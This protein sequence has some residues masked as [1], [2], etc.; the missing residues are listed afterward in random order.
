MMFA[1]NWSVASNRLYEQQPFPLWAVEHYIGHLAV[2]IDIDAEFSQ[3]RGVEVAPLF[4][5]IT[6]ID[7]NASRYETSPE[8]FA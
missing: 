5:G 2:N 6:G 7:Q 8:V 1:V 3:Q 4:T